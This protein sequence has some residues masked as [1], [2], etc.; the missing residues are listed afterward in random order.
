MITEIQEKICFKCKHGIYRKSPVCQEYDAITCGRNRSAD[1]CYN[2]A[3]DDYE[4][5]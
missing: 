5:I 2:G 4:F 3:Y 1:K